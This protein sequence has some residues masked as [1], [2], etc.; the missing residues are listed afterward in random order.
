MNPY[1]C[2]D[3]GF[4]NFASA[5]ACK[6]CKAALV[7][8]PS[9]ELAEHNSY[10]SYSTGMQPDYQTAAAYPQPVYSPQ[11]FPT[12]I[13]SLPRASKNGG[14]NAVLLSLLGVAV[15]IALGIGVLWKFGKPATANL[16]WLEY[17]AE[18]G[19]FTVE[20]PVK[21]M[22]TSESKPT[23]TG[24]MQTRILMGSMHEKGVYVIAYTDYPPNSLK[25]SPD[26]LLDFVAQGAVNNSGA[27]MISKKRITLDGYQGMEV[28]MMVPP[29]KLPGGG[30]AVC[31][32]YWTA[33]RIY[34]IFVGAPESSEVYRDR[35]RFLDS[36]KLRKKLA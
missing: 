16:G 13:A 31:R 21:P 34:T 23:P 22:V 15:I 35:M 36:F 10:G 28:E 33:P 5:S 29:D 32:I 24:D 4:L 9:S 8:A 6:R 27:T 25:V 11:Y 7:V 20:M 19:S 30:L 12:P 18:D 2:T 17:K 1:R 26:M 3:C 14:T